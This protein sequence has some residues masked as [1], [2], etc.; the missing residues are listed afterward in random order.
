MDKYYFI[1]DLG[2]V[3]SE[4]LWNKIKAMYPA[5]YGKLLIPSLK[6]TKDSLF[7]QKKD[8]R[9]F[10]KQPKN[11]RSGAHV[12]DEGRWKNSM[13]KDS[14]LRTDDFMMMEW[15]EEGNTF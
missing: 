8:L 11:C 15:G 2:V 6:E 12:W 10:K 13:L 4:N 7:V 1:E 14:F 5:G 9:L 3:A